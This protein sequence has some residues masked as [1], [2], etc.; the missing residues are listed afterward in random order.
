MKDKGIGGVGI[1]QDDNRKKKENNTLLLR[2]KIY[3]ININY[4]F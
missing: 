1:K 2:L 3:K 4:A